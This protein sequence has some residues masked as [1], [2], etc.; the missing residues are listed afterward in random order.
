MFKIQ[1]PISAGIFSAN[2]TKSEERG[3]SQDN[4]LNSKMT[5]AEGMAFSTKAVPGERYEH[6]IR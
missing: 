3:K 6:T 4:M 5:T 1:E 2:V